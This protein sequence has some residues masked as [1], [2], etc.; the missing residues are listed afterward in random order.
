MRLADVRWTALAARGNKF[1]GKAKPGAGADFAIRDLASGD[2]LDGSTAS[3]YDVALGIFLA[4][5]PASAKP[6]P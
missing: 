4:L 3:G 5:C 6:A 1:L 2:I